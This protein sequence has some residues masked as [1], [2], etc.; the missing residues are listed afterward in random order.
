M[1]WNNLE[2]LYFLKGIWELHKDITYASIFM[3][4]MP[5]LLNDY[6]F[7]LNVSSPKVTVFP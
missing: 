2:K 5:L 4:M 1:K 7:M 3:I 6:E